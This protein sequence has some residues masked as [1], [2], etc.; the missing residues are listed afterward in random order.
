MVNQYD[1]QNVRGSEGAQAAVGSPRLLKSRIR[2][3]Q[4]MVEFALISTLVMMVLLVGVQFA[5]VG[6]AALSLSQGASAIARYVAVNEPSGAVSPS[7][8]GNP[9]AAMQKLLSPSILTNSGT[10]LTIT[11][12]SYQG[13]TT[14]TPATTP[15]AT[16][17]YAVVTL[18]YNAAKK[19]AL[20]N[21]FLGISF[22][23]SL[24]ASNSQV[25]E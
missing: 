14:N 8:S 3:G 13:G 20:P 12:N 16:V 5:I 2:R 22:P 19:L 7:F 23:T 1:G 18:T 24:S 17:D 4:A 9:T 21:P 10:D 11:V 25:Y 6:Q 15:V